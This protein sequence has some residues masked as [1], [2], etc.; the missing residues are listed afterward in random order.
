[1]NRRFGAGSAVTQTLLGLIGVK[2][3]LN[4]KVKAPNFP[5]IHYKWL[6]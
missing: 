3:K 2:R 4:L 1:M 6:N 5:W